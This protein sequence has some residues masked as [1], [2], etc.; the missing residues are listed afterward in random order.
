M[1]LGRQENSK[2]NALLN[3]SNLECQ[4]SIKILQEVNIK[5]F[6]PGMSRMLIFDTYFFKYSHHGIVETGKFAAALAA[7]P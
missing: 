2:Q 4:E 5:N 3:S 1:L 6:A 7:A